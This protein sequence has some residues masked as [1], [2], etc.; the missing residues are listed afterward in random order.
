MLEQ[1]PCAR[2]AQRCAQRSAPRSGAQRPPKAGEADATQKRHFRVRHFGAMIENANKMA[3]FRTSLG[4][5]LRDFDGNRVAR[6]APDVPN[7]RQI[8]YKGHSDQKFRACGALAGGWPPRTPHAATPLRDATRDCRCRRPSPRRNAGVTC[9]SALRPE[10][11]ADRASD[12]TGTHARVGL[13]GDAPPPVGGAAAAAA[14]RVS[15]L[16]GLPQ[17]PPAPVLAP[18]PPRP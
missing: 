18:P 14:A 4:E 8:D 16:D 15:D 5:I 11:A 1:N 3:P 2:S 10:R 13:G 7:R 12:A 17:V 9:E 6:A